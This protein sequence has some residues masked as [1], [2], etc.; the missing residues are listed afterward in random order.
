M[1]VIGFSGYYAWQFLYADA[2]AS[3]AAGKVLN[4][5]GIALAIVAFGGLTGGKK[6]IDLMTHGLRALLG[7]RSND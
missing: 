4:I 3:E 2:P 1:G 6:I 5:L 7:Y